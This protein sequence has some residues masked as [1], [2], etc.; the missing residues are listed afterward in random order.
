[1]R[2][3]RR[4]ALYSA[5]MGS[6]RRTRSSHHLTRR[7]AQALLACGLGTSARAEAATLA[8][9]PSGAFATPCAAFSAAKDGDRIEIDS[10]GSYAGDV[11]AIARNSLTIAGVGGRAKIAANGKNAL[12]KGIWVVQGND[13]TIENI[14]LSGAA[15]PDKNGA[16]IRQEG[17]NLV[18]RNCY[19][20]DNEDGILAGDVAGSSITI[21]ASEF[22]RNGAGDGYSHNLY[23]NHVARLT[24]RYNYSHR[25][26]VGHL[27]KT[28]AAENYILYNRLSGEAEGT[29][30]Y[31]LDVPNGGK[32]YVIGNIIEQGA[33]TQNPTLVA[34]LAEGAHASNPSQALFIVNNSFVNRLGRG[35]FVTLGAALTTEPVVLN[36]IFYG[37]GSLP[38]QA[39]DEA[40]HNYSG[41]V[42]CFADAATLELTLV[43]NSPCVDA[44]VTPGRD[45]TFELTPEQQYVH[46]TGRALRP[47]V[48]PIDLGAYEYAASAGGATALGG[49]NG[50]GSSETGGASNGGVASRGGASNGGVSGDAGA[51]GAQNATQSGCACSVQSASKS[52]PVSVLG[53]VLAGL[54]RRRRSR[55]PHF[56]KSTRP[57]P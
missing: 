25:A 8:V 19:F 40:A 30:S 41:E 24:F 14:E 36:N 33:S 28:R 10:A 55:T 48:G 38:S 56:T 1:M 32:T 12:E 11:C 57:T 45:G 23:I 35:A 53:F 13:T 43:P 29:Q 5:I 3:D 51:A 47:T 21:E 26:R 27:L 44:G 20:H 31:E 17:K 46:P 6:L 18:V 16:G 9:G 15:V 2:R 34:Y 39:G 42:S 22:D 37:G 49:A 50:A 54:F 52:T 7:F 4:A